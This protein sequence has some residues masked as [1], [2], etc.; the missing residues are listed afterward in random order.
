MVNPQA[1]SP[2]I[3]QFQRLA[4]RFSLIPLDGKRPIEANWQRFCTTRRGFC[5]ED[6]EGKNAGICCGPA[7]GVLV[8]DVDDPDAFTAMIESNGLS[9]PET[10]QVQTGSGKP[11]YYFRYPDDGKNYGNKGIKH[12]FF[13]RHTIFDV[14]GA[15]GQV[16]APGSIHP[17]TSGRYLL[18][19]DGPV[20]NPPD[21]LLGLYEG[22]DL[23]IAVLWDSLLPQPKDREFIDSLTVSAGIKTMILAGKDRG[24]RSE[25]TASVICSLLR[26]GYSEDIIRYV[27]MH[28]PIGEK[29][30][31]K[32]AGK[33]AWLSGEI[34]RTVLSSEVRRQEHRL[35]LTALRS[36]IRRI[37]SAR[38]IRST[39]W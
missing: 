3:S 14:R 31:E 23:N 15:G 9:L 10:M 18:Y 29:Y 5:R 34:R 39:R 19:R 20:A 38:S 12:P 8:L 2:D 35:V 6:F 37:G 26:S 22:R 13:P 17:D 27:F 32:G 4:E 30:R 28:Y 36:P 33:A 24:E 25:A 7:S 1:L 11:H 21:W 16:V